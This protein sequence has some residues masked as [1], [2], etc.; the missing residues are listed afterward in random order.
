MKRIAFISG[1]EQDVLGAKNARKYYNT[2]ARAGKTAAVKR[3]YR[4]RERRYGKTE[5]AQY[6]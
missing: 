5:I 2:W 1:D 6:V 3:G 4:R